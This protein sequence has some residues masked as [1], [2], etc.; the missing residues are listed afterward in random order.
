MPENNGNGMSNKELL[1]LI[2]N[3][4]N[5]INDRIDSLHEKVNGKLSKTEFFSYSGILLS[6]AF[7][8]ANF[9]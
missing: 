7:L 8:L 3:N 2:L 5:K 6:L 1:L 4:Q 9:M